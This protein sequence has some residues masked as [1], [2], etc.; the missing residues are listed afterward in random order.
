MKRF[1]SGFLAGVVLATTLGAIAAVTYTAEPAAFKVLVNGKEFV[2]D[3]PAL[4]VEGRTYL[5]LRAMGDALGVPVNWNEA[6]R[7][8]EVGTTSTTTTSQT[9]SYS[10]INPAP[11]NTVQTY[12][13]KNPNSFIDMSSIRPDHTVNVR[14][15]EVTRGEKAN[16]LVKESNQFND[17]PKD[18]YEYIIAKV[19]VSA[20][21]VQND[22]SIEASSYDFDFYSGNN[23]EYEDTYVAF[24]GE[25]GTKIYAGGNAEGYIIGEIKKDDPNPKVVYGLVSGDETYGKAIWFDLK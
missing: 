16:R 19:A 9:T 11:L 25:L 3:P 24:E 2:S 10:R 5:P 22:A 7:Q 14:I 20:M 6:L 17:E 23:E 13:S 15:I 1:L 12:T 18:G 8:A 21:S 4:V